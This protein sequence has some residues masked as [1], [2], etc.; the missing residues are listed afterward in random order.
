MAVRPGE[1]AYLTT[2]H[3][4]KVRFHSDQLSNF[5]V[6]GCIRL[7]HRVR[8]RPPAQQP[9]VQV[10]LHNDA[11]GSQLVLSPV[12]TGNGTRWREGDGVKILP[13]EILPLF[14]KL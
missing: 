7:R 12:Q 14:G 10:P 4:D 6:P 13:W 2:Q 3:V 8:V 11:T 9:R 5:G 1:C